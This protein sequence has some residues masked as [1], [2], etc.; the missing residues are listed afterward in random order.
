MLESVL[1]MMR[2]KGLTFKQKGNTR[3]E[4]HKQSE[5]RSQS[6]VIGSVDNLS[7][8]KVNSLS[9]L[10]RK[11][12]TIYTPENENYSHALKDHHTNNGFEAGHQ[13]RSNVNKPNGVPDQRDQIKG[14]SHNYLGLQHGKE[15]GDHHINYGFDQGHLLQNNEQHR[16]SGNEFYGTQKNINREND[17]HLGIQHRN[18]NGDQHINYGSEQGQLLHINGNHRSFGNE[19]YG[20]QDNSNRKNHQPLKLLHGHENGEFRNI[21]QGDE[22]DHYTGNEHNVNHGSYGFEEGLRFSPSSNNRLHGSGQGS[23]NLKLGNFNHHSISS[24]SGKI[25]H[26]NQR[27]VATH[28]LQ[29]PATNLRHSENANKYNENRNNGLM[30]TFHT[31]NHNGNYEHRNGNYRSSNGRIKYQ[32]P[33]SSGSN[34]SNRQGQILKP[35]RSSENGNLL[36]RG[37]SYRLGNKNYESVN[38]NRNSRIINN[39]RNYLYSRRNYGSSNSDFSNRFNGNNAHTGISHLAREG[40]S[41]QRYQPAHYRQGVKHEEVRRFLRN[42]GRH[43]FSDHQRF[44]SDNHIKYFEP[45]HTGYR[46]INNG[47]TRRHGAYNKR[48]VKHGAIDLHHFADNTHY[49]TGNGRYVFIPGNKVNNHR[50]YDTQTGLHFGI[51]KIPLQGG[52]NVIVPGNLSLVVMSNREFSMATLD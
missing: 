32:Y 35:Y 15:N 7:H 51:R 45:F 33:L 49:S 12:H 4:S 37:R 18:E 50:Y 8:T 17:Q 43:I 47:D 11:R 1:P 14:E 44:N 28:Y 25:R 41:E 9:K 23:N 39:A 3:T 2:K 38:L 19:H 21:H 27:S 13:I 26:E 22:V 48:I 40:N 24:E 30:G 34:R 42:N 6:N 46:P 29:N 5:T 10:R 20:V 36:S 52:K 16:L 31:V